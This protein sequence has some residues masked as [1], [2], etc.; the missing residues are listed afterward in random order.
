[1]PREAQLINNGGGSGGT[2]RGARRLMIHPLVF[3]LLF[4][5]VVDDSKINAYRCSCLASREV[6][7][8]ERGVGCCVT[9]KSCCGI[10]FFCFPNEFI[11]FER[12]SR[13]LVH[14]YAG[15]RENLQS[16]LG[17]IRIQVWTPRDGRGW[18]WGE[19]GGKLSHRFAFRMFFERVVVRSANV[20]W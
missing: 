1:M 20:R 13:K 19:E 14:V 7:K 4:L 3:V 5:L 2:L 8:G 17:V 12:A 11:L 9:C 15:Q 6:V 10:H 16:V 18:G